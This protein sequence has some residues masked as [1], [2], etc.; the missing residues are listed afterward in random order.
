[1]IFTDIRFHAEGAALA[2][3]LLL[4][5]PTEANISH[6]ILP[7]PDEHEDFVAHHPYRVWLVIAVDGVSVGALYLTMMNEVG[8]A[9]LAAHRRKGYGTA[10]VRKII[11]A[12]PPLA[13]QTGVRNEHYIAHVAPEN[14]KSM[15]MFT[16]MGARLL[17]LTYQ[18]GG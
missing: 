14:V 13:K 5:R 8:I 11:D 7:T 4:E 6:S 3:Q 9:I 2:W 1:M 17:N 12:W 18:F 15:K 10:A 16:Q